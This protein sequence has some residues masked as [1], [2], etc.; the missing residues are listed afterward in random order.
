MR[1]HLDHFFLDTLPDRIF[2]FFAEL[3][4]KFEQ[5][6]QEVVTFFIDGEIVVR[7]HGNGK[8][9]ERDK[10]PLSGLSFQS[11]GKTWV[12]L[13]PMQEK[14]CKESKGQRVESSS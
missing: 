9:T 6:H 12:C 2:V 11:Q 5:C 4:S 8:N 10:Q 3:F 13:A 1:N 7:G 14:K